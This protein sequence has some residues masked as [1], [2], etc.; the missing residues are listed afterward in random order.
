M[1]EEELQAARQQLLPQQR[2]HGRPARLGE[3]GQEVHGLQGGAAHSADRALRHL[4]LHAALQRGV[5]QAAEAWEVPADLAQQL[6]APRLQPR[7][8]ALRPAGRAGR[9][10]GRV[11]RADGRRLADHGV[12]RANV[13]DV[14]F[15]DGRRHGGWRQGRQSWRGGAHT[16]ALQG[17]VCVKDNV[18]QDR[19]SCGYT[20][21]TSAENVVNEKIHGV[22][23]REL[24]QDFIAKAK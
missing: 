19:G 9:A 24:F 15:P 4:E 2:L 8:G 7:R 10:R 18:G 13:H 16:D 6:G 17:N 1:A 5:Q 3:H 20:P 14:F 22:R 21:R 11:H 23:G 12:V